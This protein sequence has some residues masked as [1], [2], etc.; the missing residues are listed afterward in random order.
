MKIIEFPTAK[1]QNV[2]V[3]IDYPSKHRF[4]VYSFFFYL[5]ILKGKFLTRL[6]KAS[7]TDEKAILTKFGNKNRSYVAIVPLTKSY[8]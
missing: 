2:F 5:Y 8:D 3:R 7:L 1:K 6:T 4:S